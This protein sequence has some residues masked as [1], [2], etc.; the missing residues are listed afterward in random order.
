MIKLSNLKI[1]K[2]LALVFGSAMLL[3]ASVAGLGTW[4]LLS[5]QRAVNQSQY[6]TDN[7]LLANQFSDDTA[8][9]LQITGASVMRGKAT[10]D[11][12]A[13]LAQLRQSYRAAL[14]RLLARVTDT[15][16]HRLI[17]LWDKQGATNK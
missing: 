9:V 13:Q 16:G 12:D 11:E 6:E 8:R 17:E 2:K 3:I 4:S 10:A 7:L 1:G 14:D 15:E 5:V